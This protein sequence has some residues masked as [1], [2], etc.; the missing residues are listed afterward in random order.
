MPL[1]RNS[2]RL[3]RTPTSFFF[4]F[5]FNP[6]EERFFFFKDTENKWNSVVEEWRRRDASSSCTR[7]RRRVHCLTTENV[8]HV[9]SEKT[10]TS[11][12]CYFFDLYRLYSI[13]YFIVVFSFFLLIAKP[14][15]LLK[16]ILSRCQIWLFCHNRVSNWCSVNFKC[17][18]HSSLNGQLQQTSWLLLLL[19]DLKSKWETSHY[20]SFRVG[21]HFFFLSTTCF[22]SSLC[23]PEASMSAFTQQPT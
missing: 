20:V 10:A 18:K 14:S 3:L 11:Q 8:F 21:A 6:H 22:S 12:S 2:R 19:L 23:S 5:F 13:V 1:R 16:D 15:P 9:N 7:R 4:F 17:S